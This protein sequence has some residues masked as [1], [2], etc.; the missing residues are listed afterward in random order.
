MS[1]IADCL[2]AGKSGLLTRCLYHHLKIQPYMFLCCI[3]CC[4][5]QQ[6]CLICCFFGGLEAE[7]EDLK[8]GMLG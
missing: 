8:T 2:Y 7:S 6:V 1:V 5:R 3:E 4:Q